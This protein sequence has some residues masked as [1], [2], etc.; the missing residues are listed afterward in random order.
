VI[1]RPTTPSPLRST[2]LGAGLLLA[3][4]SGCSAPEQEGEIERV[5]VVRY[6]THTFEKSWGRCGPKGE[7]PCVRG[8]LSYPSLQSGLPWIHL[9]SLRSMMRGMTRSAVSESQG[10]RVHWTAEGAIDELIR[11]Y[12]AFKEEFPDSAQTW[13]LEREVRIAYATYGVLGFTFL[14]HRDTGGAH[15]SSHTQ[16]F[17]YD[18]RRRHFVR[19]REVIAEGALERLSEIGEARF[20]ELKGIEPDAS[21][22]EAGF[23]FH[24][25]RFELSHNFL[26]TEEGLLFHWER[27]W[28][29]PYALG[30]TELTLPWDEVRDLVR[31]E[32]V[33]D[34]P[35]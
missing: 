9:V 22:A 1:P 23:T 26:V 25:D 19:L 4:L 8:R 11:E 7:E 21:L 20:R 2:L 14:E 31:P 33:P 30:P 18:V 28:I 10:E 3:A 17:C 32:Y 5:G 27:Y 34:G 29:A 24:E 6:R 35:G 12:R 13:Y 15:P 16:H